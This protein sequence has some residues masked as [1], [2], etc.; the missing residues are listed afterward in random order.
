MENEIN[1]NSNRIVQ[2]PQQEKGFRSIKRQ[3]EI[4]EGLYLYLLEKREETS[5]S[6]AV[7]VAN[8]KVVDTPYVSDTPVK[9]KKRIIWLVA[10]IV[11]FGLPIALIY[12]L[13]YLDTKVHS[14][15][16]IEETVNI[17]IIGDIPFSEEDSQ[18][19]V[20]LN[21]RSK[22]GRGLS[23]DKERTWISC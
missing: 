12:I 20:E 6:L 3:Q 5:I 23:A 14:R 19:V 10:I 1:Q 15:K 7:T 8:A 11:A 22:F 17:P 21:K 16:D 2:V 9:P 4:K 18:L 13:E